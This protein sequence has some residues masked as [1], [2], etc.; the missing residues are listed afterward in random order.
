MWREVR[1][2]ILARTWQRWTVAGVV[3]GLLLV[4]YIGFTAADGLTER[5]VHV[6]YAWVFYTLLTLV[7]CVLSGTAI[8]QEKESDTWTLLLATPTSARQIIYGKL[9]GI[10]ARLG[11]PLALISVHLL[12]FSIGGVISF[13]AALLALWVMVT[14]NSIWIATGLYLSLRVTKVTTAVIVNLLLPVLL[15]GGLSLAL[16]TMAG[17]FQWHDFA[18]SYSWYLPYYH[19]GIPLARMTPTSEND[20][21]PLPGF[22]VGGDFGAFAQIT[23]VMGL[24]HLLAATCIVYFTG[25]RFNQIVGRAPQQQPLQPHGL[26]IVVR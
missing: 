13:R 12:I 20:T 9:A 14:F 1:K 7:L 16:V 3:V 22:Q 15:Y 21:L 26:E 18:R 23:I 6:G 24:L 2:P 4:T 8:A 5:Y 19:I 25:V 11:W 17:L 10:I